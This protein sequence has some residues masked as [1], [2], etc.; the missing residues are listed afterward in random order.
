MDFKD[1]GLLGRW[2]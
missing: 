2:R 1:F